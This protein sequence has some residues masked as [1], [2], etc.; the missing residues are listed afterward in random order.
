MT[1]NGVNPHSVHVHAVVEMVHEIGALVH[2]LPPYSPDYN[3]IEEAFSKVKAQLRTMDIESFE[4]PED[5]V[6]AAFTTIT[7][8]N[9][10]QWI[11][12]AGIFNYSN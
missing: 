6:M 7:T 1:F 2:F 8:E 11:T 12:N 5:F 9:C 10:Q 3:P 4:D